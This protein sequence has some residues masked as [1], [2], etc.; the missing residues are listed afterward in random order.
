MAGK[1]A[2]DKM[3]ATMKIQVREIS[4]TDTAWD[5]LAASSRQNCL[6]V[7]RGFLDLWAGEDPSLRLLKLGCYDESNR[8]VCGQAIIHRKIMGVRVQNILSTFYAGTPVLAGD[9]EENSPEQYEILS[10][11]ARESRKRFPYMRIEFHPNLTDARAYLDN[12]WEATPIYTHSWKLEDMQE[13]RKGMHRKER[14][15]R[16]AQEMFDLGHEHGQEIIKD[17]LRL[18]AETMK[19]Y[20]WQPTSKW[21]EAFLRKMKWLESRDLLHIYTCRKKTGELV[22]ITL[23]LL[24]R[25]NQTAYFWLIGYDHTIDSKEFPPAIYYYASEDLSSEFKFIDFGEG[26]HASLYAFKDSLGT[27]STPFWILKTENNSGWSLLHSRLRK[28]RQ[29]LLKFVP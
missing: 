22:G 29:F 5:E 26:A 18:Y 9:I 13:V 20:D 2:W 21:R 23:S 11:L 28:I 19:K 10:A 25:E 1:S 15:I 3:D 8:L 6:F 14:Y 7:S 17:F 24:S 4:A 16:K 27:T 12:G